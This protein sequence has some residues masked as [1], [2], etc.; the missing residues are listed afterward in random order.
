MT[1]SLDRIKQLIESF[2]DKDIGQEL[3]K[4]YKENKDQL[5]ALGDDALNFVLAW[6]T[7]Q[8][9]KARKIYLKNW[10]EH[11]DIKAKDLLDA[12]NANLKEATKRQKEKANDLGGKI[13]E[14]GAKL[15]GG[16]LGL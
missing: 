12:A 11:E 14:L 16:L 1:I 15:L 5:Q 9:R 6:I 7:G 10:Y 13:M 3:D 8:E 2:G 4:F